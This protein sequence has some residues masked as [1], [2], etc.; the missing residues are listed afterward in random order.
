LLNYGNVLKALGRDEEALSYCDR[1]L[2]V[3]A[4]HAGALY[5]RG[6]LLLR[7]QRWDEALASYAQVLAAQPDFVEAWNNQGLA[8]YGLRRCEEA[9]ASYD[10]ALALKPDHAEAHCNRGAALCL[11]GRL[12][13]ALAACEKAVTLRPQYPEAWYGRG[14]VMRDKARMEDAMVSF[15]RA[16]A[17]RPDYAEAWHNRGNALMVL[18]S[19][20]DAAASFDKA[21]A[22][23][24]DNA[25]ALNNRGMCLCFLGRVDEALASYDKALALKPDYADA[26]HSRGMVRWREGQDYAA[27]IQ[28]LERTAALAPQHD[29]VQGDLL[30]V[31]MHGADWTDFAAQAARI[32]E[33]V[34]AGRLTIDPFMYLAVSDSPADL[35]ACATA[36]AAHF[37]PAA[38]ALCKTGPRSREKIRIGYVSGEFRAQAT[39]YL[40]A[41]LYERHDRSRFEIVAFDAGP[42]ADSAMRRRLEGAFDRFIRIADLSDRAAAET[43]VNADIDILVNLNG[44]F[45]NH[46]M[47]V[48]AQRPAPLQ[49]N[50]L[51]FPGTLGADYMDYI[52]ADRCVIPE[53]EERFYTEKVVILPDSYQVNDSKRHRP[54]GRP[55]RA[56]HQLPETGFVFCNFNMNYKFTPEMFAV[57]M[58]LLKQVQGSVLWLLE[59]NA[60]APAHLRREAEKHGVAPERLVFAPFIAMEQQLDRLQL[61]DLFIDSVPCNAHTTASDALWAGVPLLTCYGGAFSGRVAASLLNAVGLPELVTR[62]LDDYAALAQALAADPARLSGLRRKLADNLQGAPL[63]DTERYRRHLEAAYVRMWERRERGDAPQGFAV[64]PLS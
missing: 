7:L 60:T 25:E 8:L 31:R 37:H 6:N 51:G 26:L 14:I 4:N 9:V 43:I 48:F 59:G 35:Q 17:L 40:T 57:W 61:A 38:P 55:S 64:A 11:L 49:V 56:A 36:F 12:D 39:A 2:D 32:H 19:F 10:R 29:C 53:A 3:E 21:L 34:R 45:G 15:D 44:Y 13:E 33:G 5:N 63:F 24:P 16:L 20:G 54:E 23:N 46:R 22:L 47:G 41:G 52:V 18:K 42:A 62:D 50:F 1:V 28:D 58:R 30:H 27:A